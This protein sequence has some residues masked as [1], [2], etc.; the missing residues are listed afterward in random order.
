LVRPPKVPGMEPLSLLFPRS[1]FCNGVK[2]PELEGMVPWKAF[3]YRKN[4]WSCSPCETSTGISS[5]R[6]FLSGLR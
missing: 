2:F 1:K 4:S 6:L 3:C 5:I